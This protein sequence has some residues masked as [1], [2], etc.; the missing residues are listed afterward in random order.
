LKITVDTVGVEFDFSP[1]RPVPFHEAAFKTPGKRKAEETKSG[2]A[3]TLMG[4]FLTSK[5]ELLGFA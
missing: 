3:E 2:K 5:V 1:A 4:R